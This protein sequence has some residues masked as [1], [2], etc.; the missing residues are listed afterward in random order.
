MKDGSGKSDSSIV[1]KKYPNKARGLVAEGTEGRELAKGNPWKRNVV[2][3]Q[4]REAAHKALERVRQAVTRDRRQRFT[5]LFHHV[6]QV[7]RLREAYYAL[8]RDAAARID[9][10][11]WKHY[12]EELE[13]NL[14]DLSER[15][16]RG[17]Y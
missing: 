6:Y 15:L 13:T 9:G 12:G 1:P 3:T 4:G 10:E 7:D 8:E 5:A 11:T 16:K 2:R 17:A 14:Q